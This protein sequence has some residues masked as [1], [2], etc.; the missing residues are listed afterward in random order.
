MNTYLTVSLFNLTVIVIGPL[1]YTMLECAR[2]LPSITGLP[3]PE[4]QAYASCVESASMPNVEKIPPHQQALLDAW[5]AR[6]NL[7]RII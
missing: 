2:T 4:L 7:P 1:P 5:I 3:I 6:R